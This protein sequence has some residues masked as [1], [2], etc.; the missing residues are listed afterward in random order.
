MRIN[1]GKH[2]DADGIKPTCLASIQNWPMNKTKQIRIPVNV[3]AQAADNMWTL[4]RKITNREEPDDASPG[5][6]LV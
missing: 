2:C 5:C 6:L 4:T 3:F 1:T